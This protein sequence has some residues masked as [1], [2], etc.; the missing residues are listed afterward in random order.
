MTNYLEEL[1]YATGRN[2]TEL[3]RRKNR[4]VHAR[5][6]IAIAEYTIKR[7]NNVIAMAKKEIKEQDDKMWSYHE[8]LKILDRYNQEVGA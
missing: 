3:D 5:H 8:G 7:L 6:A 2:G 1:R 4:T